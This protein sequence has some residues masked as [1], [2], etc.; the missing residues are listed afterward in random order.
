MNLREEDERPRAHSPPRGRRNQSYIEVAPG[1]M[2]SV[3]SLASQALC[4][5]STHHVAMLKDVVFDK[6]LEIYVNVRAE[7]DEE[8]VKGF[9]AQPPAGPF[10][11]VEPM[12]Y[13][14]GT[15]TATAASGQPRRD[16]RKHGGGGTGLGAFSS[17]FLPSWYCAEAQVARR[18]PWSYLKD[19]SR[20]DDLCAEQYSALIYRHRMDIYRH[21]T[22][23]TPGQ[24]GTID[25]AKSGSSRGSRRRGRLRARNSNLQRER[26]VT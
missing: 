5:L 13:L 26:V 10:T 11:K 25:T 9:R 24:E 17:S 3:R 14:S 23:T 12:M 15:G 22:R 6:L 8:S 21:A 2:K 20:M 1:S 16:K 19:R 7:E 18:A 4:T